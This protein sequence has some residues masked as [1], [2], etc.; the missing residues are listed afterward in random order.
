MARVA[1]TTRRGGTQDL[2]YFASIGPL[3]A[4]VLRTMAA[5]ARP[6]TVRE[7]CDQLA[8]G[9]YF[10]H[11]SVLNCSTRLVKKGFLER[12]LV[13]GAYLLCL[14]VDTA[15]LAACLAVEAITAM[16]A[17]RDRVVCRLL[18][19]DPERGAPRI[20]RLRAETKALPPDPRVAGLLTHITGPRRGEG[21]GD[22]GE[23]G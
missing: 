11:Q 2:P 6:A 7:V 3:E 20:A 18:G 1:E 15:E 12:T 9:G 17:D 19:L 23:L 16:G 21:R 8:P 4:S 14:G 13:E 5:I 10:T 22:P